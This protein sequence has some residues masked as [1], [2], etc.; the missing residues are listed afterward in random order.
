MSLIETKVSFVSSDLPVLPPEDELAEV[1]S[2]QA[3][4]LNAAIRAEQCSMTLGCEC[5][6]AEPYLKYLPFSDLRFFCWMG[7]DGLSV[8]A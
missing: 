6:A 1:P 7:R 2:A 8:P 4:K 5:A 3:V